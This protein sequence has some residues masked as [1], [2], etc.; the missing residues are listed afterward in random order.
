MVSASVLS[1][2]HVSL[3]RVLVWF[4][5][6]R[7]VATRICFGKVPRYFAANALKGSADRSRGGCVSLWSNIMNIRI[8]EKIGA[9][10][11]VTALLVLGQ[12]VEAQGTQEALGPPLVEPQIISAHHGVAELTLEAGPSK[13][14]VGDQSFISNVYNGQ[15]I[16]PVFRLRRGD[17][18]QL[19]LVN[20][21][22][23]ADVQIDGTQAT[24]LHYHGMSVSPRPPADDIYVTI[25]SLQMIE[26][27]T[28]VHQHPGMQMRDNYVY[29]TDGKC[30]RITI[31]APSGITRMPMGRQKVRC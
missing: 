12:G 4:H 6:V 9:A 29:G 25:P 22:G 17:E 31:R 19:R 10:A 20:R 18:L 28:L 5:T 30:R 23:P 21:I 2:D 26:D 3:H 14:T 1:W 7:P 16:P 24:N 13:V 15:Y 27:P 8:A 11:V